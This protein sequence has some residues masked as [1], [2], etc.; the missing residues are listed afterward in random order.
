M[1]PGTVVEEQRFVRDDGGAQAGRFRAG[2]IPEID[3]DRSALGFLQP[4][5]IIE[6][7]GDVPRLLQLAQLTDDPAHVVAPLVFA[8]LHVR[9]LTFE[10]RYNDSWQK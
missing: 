10:S 3:E 5:E 1:C 7:H 6:V 4:F 9:E 8:R 2:I